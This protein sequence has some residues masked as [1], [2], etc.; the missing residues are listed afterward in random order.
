MTE[1]ELFKM[2][3]INQPKNVLVPLMPVELQY[4]SI[5]LNRLRSHYIR[6][7]VSIWREYARQIL[8]A[9][10]KGG[11][12]CPVFGTYKSGVTELAPSAE[13][14]EIVGTCFDLVDQSDMLHINLAQIVANTSAKSE[15]VVTNALKTMLLSIRYILSRKWF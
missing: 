8:N 10:E 2:A 9:E 14:C 6:V 12:V 11:I 15:Q 1:L 5:D 3:A 13:L 7:M 4:P